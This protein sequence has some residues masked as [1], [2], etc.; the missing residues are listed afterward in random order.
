MT[1]LVSAQLVLPS[2]IKRDCVGSAQVTQTGHTPGFGPGSDY[3]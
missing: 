2:G 3:R 1:N